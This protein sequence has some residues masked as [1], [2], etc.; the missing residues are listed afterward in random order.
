MANEDLIAL[1]KE[2]DRKLALAEIPEHTNFEV[3][4]TSANAELNKGLPELV[5]DDKKLQNEVV[6]HRKRKFNIF[7]KLDHNT[8]K[9]QADTVEYSTKYEKEQIYYKRHKG[10][11]D[12]YNV[13][14]NSGFSKMWSVVAWDL[15]VTWVCYIV[16]FPI[17]LLK[18]A[19]E[20]FASMKRSIMWS[21]IIVVVIIIVI[22]GLSVGISAIMNLAEQAASGT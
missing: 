21:V 3:A 20:L 14:E 22:V 5:N 16:G 2:V 6:K 7:R 4:R 12:Q 10:I 15:F 8:T 13:P 9:D 11:L 18:K 17:Y 1:S 19:V